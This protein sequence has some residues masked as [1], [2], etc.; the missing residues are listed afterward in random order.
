MVLDWEKHV[1]LAITSCYLTRFSYNPIKVA[2]FIETKTLQKPKYQEISHFVDKTENRLA[3]IQV[4][5]LWGYVLF[6]A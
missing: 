2:R 5:T 1:I 3:P 4:G 6:Q